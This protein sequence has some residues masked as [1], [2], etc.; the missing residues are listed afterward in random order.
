ML[1][2][3]LLASGRK[4][5]WIKWTKMEKE[6]NQEVIKFEKEAFGRAKDAR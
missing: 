5:P 4:T 3:N 1:K 6:E 2:D